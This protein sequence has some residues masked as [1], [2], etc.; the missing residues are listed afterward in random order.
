MSSTI[1]LDRESLNKALLSASSR[2]DSSDC[3]I[4]GLWPDLSTAS[5]VLRIANSISGVLDANECCIDGD[6]DDGKKILDNFFNLLLEVEEDVRSTPI[7]QGYDD[8]AFVIAIEGLDGC[9]KRYDYLC[10]NVHT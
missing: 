8:N 2:R 6:I 3:N 10:I 4:A 9:G 7:G 5:S 1:T